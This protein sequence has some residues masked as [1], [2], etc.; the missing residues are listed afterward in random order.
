[1][2]NSAFIR[3]DLIDSK[4]HVDFFLYEDEITETY[5]VKTNKNELKY[6]KLIK[7]ECTSIL[8]VEALKKALDL[9]NKNN[10]QMDYSAI[11][12]E[13]RKKSKRRRR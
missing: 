3:G 7:S 13:C 9:I 1:M 5:R 10:H 11:L 12:C 8:E 6:L 2:T 4:Y